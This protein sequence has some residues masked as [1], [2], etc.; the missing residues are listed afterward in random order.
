MRAIARTNSPGR[1]EFSN[2][3]VEGRKTGVLGPLLRSAVQHRWFLSSRPGDHGAAGIHRA[4]YGGTPF[5]APHERTPLFFRR[6]EIDSWELIVAGAPQPLAGHPS[7]R[8]VVEGDPQT[9]GARRPYFRACGSRATWGKSTNRPPRSA[10]GASQGSS[11]QALSARSAGCGPARW[12]C[13]PLERIPS[14][15]RE[16][17]HVPVAGQGLRWSRSLLSSTSTMEQ[18]CVLPFMRIAP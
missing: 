6:C 2:S 8:T 17:G 13:L 5:R 18:S 9:Q 10:F 12:S 16:T 15:S 14:E 4:D 11:R 3:R 7:G 1:V